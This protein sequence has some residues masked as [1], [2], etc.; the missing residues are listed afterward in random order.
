[1]LSIH[2]G[3]DFKKISFWHIKN[4]IQLKKNKSAGELRWRIDLLS[5]L[6]GISLF[7]SICILQRRM[8]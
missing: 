7:E 4:P 3:G 5:E 8:Q 1:M 2:G 6:I